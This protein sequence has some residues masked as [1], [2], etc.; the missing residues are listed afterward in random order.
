[1][2]TNAILRRAGKFDK[3]YFEEID[4]EPK[5]YWLGFVMGDGCVMWDEATGN[6]SLTV[7]LQ[8]RDLP[9]LLLLTKDLGS[10]KMP[11][12]DKRTASFRMVWYS[13]RLAQSLINLGVVPRKSIIG[14]PIPVIT[15]AQLVRHFWRGLFDADGCLAIQRKSNV[16]VPEYRF[17]LAGT[18][19][20]LAAFQEWAMQTTDLRPQKIGRASNQNGYSRA[21]VIAISGNRQIEALLYG[22]YFDS[23]RSLARKRKLFN[24]LVKQ[25]AMV[26]PSYLRSYARPMV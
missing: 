1:M 20:L 5:A 3:G 15:Q 10:T 18:R 21:H 13:K 14:H 19:N 26:K 16:S 12:L 7:A 23:T 6:Y 24:D 2:D 9:H 17:S 8:A 25:N 11:I 4:S 22:M